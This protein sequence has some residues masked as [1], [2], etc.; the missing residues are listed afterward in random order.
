MQ[1]THDWIRSKAA[2]AIDPKRVETAL[3]SLARRWP[4]TGPSLR[5]AVE[6]AALGEENL[7]HLLAIS[8]VSAATLQRD[9]S[10]LLWLNRREIAMSGRDI[11]E[12]TNELYRLGA[13][14]IAANNF[15]EL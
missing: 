9:P 8:D 13:A 14:A 5:Q 7:I 15:R 4:E 2:G 3:L 10:I 11:N 1:E 12:M 6:N